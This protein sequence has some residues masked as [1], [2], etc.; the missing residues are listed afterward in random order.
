VFK[1]RE[2]S[3]S[4]AAA[5]MAGNEGEWPLRDLSPQVVRELFLSYST[6]NDPKTGAPCLS[7][8][9][10]EGF[11]CALGHF[12][13]AAG[14]AEILARMDTDG[15]NL[16]DFGEFLAGY[17][18]VENPFLEGDQG[19]EACSLRDFDNMVALFRTLDHDG[20]SRISVSDL[21]GLLSTAGN[22]GALSRSEAEQIV[23]Q[24][25]S[26][27]DGVVSLT[28]F[29]EMLSSSSPASQRAAWRLRSGLRL[30][31]VVG[32]PGSG[33]GVLCDRLAQFAGIAHLSCG[34]LLR[35]EVEAGTH[36][37]RRVEEKLARGELVDSS[38]IVALLRKAMARKPG[39]TVAYVLFVPFASYI[40]WPGISR[41]NLCCT[42]TNPH[43]PLL[44]EKKPRRVSAQ[45][46]KLPRPLCDGGTAGLC[47]LH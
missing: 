20:D 3:D 15:N 35:A 37:G 2:F 23:Q 16:I 33:K 44:L 17:A 40:A 31:L 13:P 4:V 22:T 7:L 27:Q 11:L 42:G 5:G 30:I 43:F 24:A 10:L 21:E 46:E 12:F 1:Y 34:D 6:S 19:V 18:A 45:S 36:L 32:G 14:V 39:T 38:T 26:D 29:V 28:E 25:D 47:V 9:D 8:D 41:A